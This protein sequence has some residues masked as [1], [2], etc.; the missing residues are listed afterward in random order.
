MTTFGIDHL[1]RPDNRSLST[2]EWGLV[3]NDAATTQNGKK[4]RIALIEQDWNI[5][6][7]F[8]P[9][10]GIATNGIDGAFQVDR[11]DPL[12]N[13]PVYSLYGT[14][15]SPPE[16]VLQ[17]LDGVIFDL[18]DTGVRFY[19]Y[20][21]TLSHVMEA[22]VNSDKLLLVL[23]RPNPLSGKLDVI[24]GPLLDE[25][26]FSS[27]IGRWRIPIRHSLTLGELALYWKNSRLPELKLEVIPCQNWDRNEYFEALNLPFVPPS[28]A[29]NFVDT[30]LTY[31]ALCFFEGLNVNEGR[32]TSIPFQQFGAPWI[33]SESFCHELNK[34]QISGVNFQAVNYI[35]ASSRYA[36]KICQG[37]R[38]HVVDKQSYRP[39]KT[40]L[41]I[42]A[43]L[44]MNYPKHIELDTYP[45]M[46]NPSGQLHLDLLLGNALPTQYLL[47]NPQVLI[48]EL[49]DICSASDWR[50]EVEKYLL[51]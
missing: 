24:E 13:L 4:S 34:L 32:G 23:D 15:I 6:C 14:N 45:T 38:L 37:I 29:I 36:G 31:P 40:G 47:N 49:D 8:S 21:W 1:L 18:P 33:N 7:L 30:F 43:H 42:L 27:F 28:P 41:L 19:T 39:I 9:E 3:T 12:T 51:Y 22:C 48:N 10:H 2:K 20:L 16:Q 35:P 50:E 5:K 26:N 17:S 25:A 46:V 11:V 44:F